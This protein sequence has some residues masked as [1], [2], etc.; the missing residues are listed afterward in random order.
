MEFSPSCP[1]CQGYLYTN[2]DMYGEYQECL[3]CGFMVHV[4]ERDDRVPAASTDE[5]VA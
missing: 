4:V 1:R 5:E 3:Q 2:R